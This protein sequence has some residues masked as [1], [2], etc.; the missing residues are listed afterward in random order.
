[1]LSRCTRSK[2]MSLECARARTAHF[3]SRALLLVVLSR[4]PSTTFLF[5]SSTTLLLGF[6][7]QIVDNW[8]YVKYYADASPCHPRRNLFPLFA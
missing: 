1:M 3:H 2:S 4:S 6:Y 7:S 8:D 5:G